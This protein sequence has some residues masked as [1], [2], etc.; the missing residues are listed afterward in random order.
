M[1]AVDIA[2]RKARWRAYGFLFL[3]ALSVVLMA[4]IIRGGGSDFSHGLWLGVLAGSAFNLTPVKR[5]LRP[6][7]AVVRLLDDE[8]TR[9]YRHLSCTAG[10]W[11]SA[12]AAIAL[13]VVTRFVD[14]LTAADV[15]QIIATAGIASAML[16]FAALELRAAR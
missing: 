3:A 2:E 16:A 9:E 13:A 12:V 11:A 14:S 15:A 7:S 4:F 5:W 6:N 1:T 10:F 8:A